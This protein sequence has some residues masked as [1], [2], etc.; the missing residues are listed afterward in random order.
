MA[1]CSRRL[2]SP[3]LDHFEKFTA[4]KV[5]FKCCEAVLAYHSGTSSMNKNLLSHHPDI[6]QISELFEYSFI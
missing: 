4:K 6:C 5:K 3:V 2:R 1:S